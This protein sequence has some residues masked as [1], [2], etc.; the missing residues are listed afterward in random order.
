MNHAYYKNN[1]LI[2]FSDNSKDEKKE[3][4]CDAGL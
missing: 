1:F 4:N 2:F 3:H